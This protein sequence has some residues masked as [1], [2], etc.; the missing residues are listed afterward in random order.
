MNYR[1]EL[2]QTN[3]F[4]ER[5][6]SGINDLILKRQEE[7]SENRKVLVKDIFSTPEDYRRDLKKMLGWP[8]VGYTGGAAPKV[9]SERIAE[10]DG[11]SVYR[12]SF[13]IL[14]ELEM[15]GLYFRMETD[16]AR[17]LVLVQHGGLGTPELISGIYGSTANYNDMLER[18]IRHKVHAFAPQLLLW[19]REKYGIEFDRAAIDVSLKRVG[20]S[21]TA[22]ELYGM[23]RILDHFETQSEVSSFGMVGLSYGGFYTLYMSAVDTRIRS[24]ISC[25]FFNTRDAY[26]WSDWTWFNSAEKFDDA[27]VACLS[28]PRRLCIEIADK[29]SLFDY[30][31]GF[32]SFERIKELSSDVG[33]DW[34]DLICFDGT[35]EFCRDDA[36]IERLINDLL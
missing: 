33:G 34:I 36:P 22:I 7:F 30:K 27:E 8:L 31:N 14:P 17:P 26:R 23:M 24:A 29:D 16:E 15:T 4:K 25:A 28:Y 1:E 3:E 5:Y 11:Y 12:M 20:S 19:D 21:I 2:A 18:V 10:E 35:H 6:L 13:E 32:S 9:R